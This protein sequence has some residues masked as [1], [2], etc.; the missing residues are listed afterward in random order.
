MAPCD[1]QQ[2]FTF[3]QG[4]VRARKVSL[5]L[6]DQQGGRGIPPLWLGTAMA[7][8]RRASGAMLAVCAV[9][10]ARRFASRALTGRTASAQVPVPGPDA[11]PVAADV[12]ETGRPNADIIE[13][14]FPFFARAEGDYEGIPPPAV[15]EVYARVSYAKRRTHS[16][17]CEE[18]RLE[19]PIAQPMDSYSNAAFLITGV[20]AR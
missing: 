7:R 4:H 19:N 17:Y 15:A 16:G 14:W 12:R 18:V 9:R 8:A 6:F 3:D 1:P 2:E 13:G 11:Q 5:Q 10:G 20:R